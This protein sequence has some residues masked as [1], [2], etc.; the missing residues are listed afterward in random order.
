M[1]NVQVERL[2]KKV[3]SAEERAQRALQVRIGCLCSIGLP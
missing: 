3:E 2:E 1:Q